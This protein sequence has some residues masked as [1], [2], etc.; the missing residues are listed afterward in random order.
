MN[1]IY[2][3][4]LQR[5]DAALNQ[6]KANAR[7]VGHEP[8]RGFL[9]RA[10]GGLKPGMDRISV[11]LKL[12]RGHA[13]GLVPDK[14]T[15]L[16]LESALDVSPIVREFLRDVEPADHIAAIHANA[17]QIRAEYGPAARGQILTSKTLDENSL[18]ELGDV[19]SKPGE[20][21]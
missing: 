10:I 11:E 9:G 21:T 3:D 8:G 19:L 15:E 6:L 2:Q 4:N 17:E 7:A 1:E 12:K 5:R 16:G 18:R 20:P 13:V 14:I